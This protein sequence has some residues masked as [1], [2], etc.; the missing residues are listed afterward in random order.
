VTLALEYSGHPM[1]TSE[2]HEAAEQLA[3]VP[4]SHNSI[5]AALAAGAAARR[6]RFKRIRRGYYRLAD[7][8]EH[9]GDGSGVRWA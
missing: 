6:P 2:I 7:C 5:K 8:Q 9:D 1:R 3:G 4:L